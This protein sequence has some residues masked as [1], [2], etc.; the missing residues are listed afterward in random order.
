M[1][2]CKSCNKTLNEGFFNE[3]DPENCVFCANNKIKIEKVKASTDFEVVE[4]AGCGGGAC[5]L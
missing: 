3:Q 1:K 2:E 5:T 4:E